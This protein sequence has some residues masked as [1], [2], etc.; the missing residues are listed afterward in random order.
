MFDSLGNWL[1]EQGIREASVEEVV[2]GFGRGLVDAGVSVNQVCLGALLLRPVFGALDVVWNGEDDTINSQM[3]PRSVVT[4]EEF[5]NSPFFWAMSE[6]VPFRQFRF[7]EGA[8]TPD[9]L[10]FERLRSEG[11]TDYLLFFESYDRKLDPIWADLPSGMEGVILFVSTCRKGGF[12]GME[13]AYLQAMMRPLTLNIKSST[14]HELSRALLDTYLGRYSGNR[15]LE[16]VVERGDGGIIDCVLFYSDL[17]DS[18][19]LAENL[20]L[21]GYLSLINKYFDCSAGAVTNHAARF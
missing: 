1:T 4:T 18:T 9:F 5:Q 17:R 20:L 7:G 19:E 8:V 16:G 6:H 15:V 12:A 3:M 14:T 11:V 13:I 21:D 10:I 2:Q